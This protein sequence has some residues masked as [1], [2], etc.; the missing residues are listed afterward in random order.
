MLSRLRGFARRHRYKLL[1]V[2]ALGGAA[3]LLQ[4]YATRRLR[5]WGERETHR[6]LEKVKKQAHFESTRATC[7][8]SLG[9]LAPRLLSQ[10]TRVLDSD[11][12]LEALRAGAPDK[13]QVWQQLKRLALQRVMTA[14]YGAAYL[15][16]LLE[17]HV[18]ALGGCLYVD[19]VRRLLAEPGADAE[20]AALDESA[21]ERYLAGV[22]HLLTAGLERLSAD[23]APLLA[24][25]ADR[26]AL[27]DKLGLD[28]VEALLGWARSAVRQR[29]EI[30]LSRYA[31]PESVTARSGAAEPAGGR[32]AQLAAE[33]RDLVDNP[34]T[35][36]LVAE[37]VQAGLAH[38]LDQM[39]GA[40]SGQGGGSEGFVPPSAATLPVAKLVPAL[41]NLPHTLLRSGPDSL[42]WMLSNHSKVQVLA[43]NVYESFSEVT[44]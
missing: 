11:S 15:V 1:A 10:L 43:A 16:V 5:D 12:L 39:V 27:T 4:W 38:V 36:E 30:R 17:V 8:S 6:M 41:T 7:T 2:G 20:A 23:L 42:V 19:S 34:E 35:E 14:V 40:F 25:L 31:Y 18:H 32:V 21:Q 28:G 44:S 13:L 26:L 29:P 37:C 24:P 22:E 3:Y 9:Q 33:T